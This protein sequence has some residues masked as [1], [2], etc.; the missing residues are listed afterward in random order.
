MNET[1]TKDIHKQI[2]SFINEYTD[3][4]E[5]EISFY[6]DKDVSSIITSERINNLNVV[7]NT[8]TQNNEEKYKT[9]NETTLDISLSIKNDKLT[10]YRITITGI[11]EI[12]EYIFTYLII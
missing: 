9:K 8:I 4:N 10:N 7:L 2:D 6:K 5:F 1:I 12:N 3:K 11:N